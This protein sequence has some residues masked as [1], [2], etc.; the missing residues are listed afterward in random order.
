MDKKS[1]QL[2]MNVWEGER[3]K[4]VK[5]LIPMEDWIKKYQIK[6]RM[7]R[8]KK[9]SPEKTWK[10]YNGGEWQK[11]MKGWHLKAMHQSDDWENMSRARIRAQELDAELRSEAKESYYEAMWFRVMGRRWIT[12][13]SGRGRL[14]SGGKSHSMGMKEELES[15]SKVWQSEAFF[16][17]AGYELEQQGWKGNAW[18]EA[19][20]E[21]QCLKLWIDSKMRDGLMTQ[22][23]WT[24]VY[25]EQ[26]AWMER[27]PKVAQAWKSRKTWTQGLTQEEVEAF[28]RRGWSEKARE[29]FHRWN[30][31]GLDI[32][33]QKYRKF[34]DKT[35]SRRKQEEAIGKWFEVLNQQRVKH[36]ELE[37]VEQKMMQNWSGGKKEDEGVKSWNVPG[38]YTLQRKETIKMRGQKADM[39]WWQWRCYHA[40]VSGKDERVPET[41]DRKVRGRGFWERIRM[42]E[43]FKEIKQTNP[44][45]GVDQEWINAWWKERLKMVRWMEREEAKS[46]MEKIQAG[47]IIQDSKSRKWWIEDELMNAI[48]D[49]RR[50]NREH[51]EQMDRMERGLKW[52]KVEQDKGRTWRQAEGQWKILKG[53]NE[54]E[55]EAIIKKKLE[56]NWESQSAEMD[57]KTWVYRN[58][59]NVWAGTIKS[60]GWMQRWL[61]LKEVHEA[62]ENFW[63]QWQEKKDQRKKDNDWEAMM[64]MECDEVKM[65][66]YDASLSTG[67]RKSWNALPWWNLKHEQWWGE[68]ETDE[69]RKRESQVKGLLVRNEVKDT[70]KMWEDWKHP[71]MWKW[72]REEQEFG[73]RLWGDHWTRLKERIQSEQEQKIMKK[74]LK[75][76]VHRPK[77]KSAGSKRL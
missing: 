63:A 34:V 72:V 1:A 25:E 37:R 36:S 39:E 5:K 17:E 43:V 35:A 6:E 50:E 11:K 47:E 52:E 49:W 68:K 58:L 7:K 2:V 8:S 51:E 4:R 26:E 74:A 28:D 13:L 46:W 71:E 54:K 56:V 24:A 10:D 62:H 42:D 18:E 23:G 59:P 48:N 22:E 12:S 14:K 44:K 31:G 55:I 73:I 64:A 20:R 32:E 33:Y 3:E 41:M 77:S 60:G 70:E 38:I 45:E 9:I 75:D 67:I 65:M 29:G 15:W 19:F 76:G 21:M 30:T 53:C 69:G 61:S 57:A 66:G 40:V 27:H 16:E